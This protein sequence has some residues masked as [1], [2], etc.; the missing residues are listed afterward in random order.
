M[1]PEINPLDDAR[2]GTDMK[3]WVVGC[4]AWQVNSSAWEALWR[5]ADNA[6]K[7][8]NDPVRAIAEHVPAPVFLDRMF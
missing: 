2:E 4:G 3:T 7:H 8:V 1:T 6:T 5:S